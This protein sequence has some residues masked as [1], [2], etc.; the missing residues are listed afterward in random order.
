[1]RYLIFLEVAAYFGLEN[2][3]DVF[4]VA[5]FVLEIW[6]SFDAY[7][8]VLGEEQKPLAVKPDIQVRTVGGGLDKEEKDIYV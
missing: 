8:T 6:V 4:L 1:M 2:Y 5:T 7:R 3:P